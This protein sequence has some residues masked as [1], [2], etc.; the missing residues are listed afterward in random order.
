MDRISRRGRW[1]LALAGS[2]L[3]VFAQAGRA[4]HQASPES[5]MLDSGKRCF[6]LQD[7]TSPLSVIQLTIGGGKAAIPPGKDGLA[8][9]ATRLALE[10]P[11]RDK[12]RALMA[13]ATMVTM[14]VREDYSAIV[15]A[16]LS[17]NLEDALRVTSGIIKKP[18]FSR[19]RIDAIKEI[20][21]IQ[22]RAEADDSVAAGHAAALGGLFEGEGR[23]SATYGTED[24]LKSIKKKDLLA[25]HGQFFT[26]DGIAFSVC[27]DLGR[28]LIR[29]LLVRYFGDF[30][31]G[32]E[33]SLN[34]APSE[35]V[36]PKNR[37]IRRFRDTRQSYIGSAFVLPPVSP[38]GYAQ[39][40][41]LEILLGKSPG[42]RLWELRTRERLAYN[43][44]A[45]VTWTRSGGVLEAYLETQNDNR[46]KAL[47]GLSGILTDLWENGLTEADLEA[48]KTLAKSW[49]LRSRE[50]KEARAAAM[51]RF[52]A[53]GLG[54]GYL[55]D[56][57]GAVDEVTLEAMNGYLRNV[58]G[59]GRALV[60]IVGPERGI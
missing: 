39:A 11:D 34:P 19:F 50:S 58:L 38:A 60:V 26:R 3:L 53:L 45:R 23:G 20:M 42:S 31:E 54:A 37:T 56:L 21:T 32:R 24:S 36:L 13:Q 51:G 49:F 25:Y 48:T 41:L 5:L 22:G 29:G 30:S 15:I 57:I 43:V 12:A 44:D 40:F 16:S 8:H 9:L 27:T 2:L 28:D 35:P 59:P 46:E 55:S 52:D 1:P 10:I 47:L 7:S 14:T 4:E 18:L 33:D 6:Y 17:E